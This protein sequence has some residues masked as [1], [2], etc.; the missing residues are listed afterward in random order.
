MCYI[1]NTYLSMLE[2]EPRVS[3]ILITCS[4]TNNVLSS[5]GSYI[6]KMTQLIVLDVYL[7][8]YTKISNPV[9]YCMNIQI[10]EFP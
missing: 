10:A 7:H 4:N 1:H 6:I 8:N 2:T 5:C 3:F 9:N